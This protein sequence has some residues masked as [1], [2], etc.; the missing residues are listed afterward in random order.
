MI[1][2]LSEMMLFLN[3]CFFSGSAEAQ[4]IGAVGNY[5]TYWLLTFSVTRLPN[6][7]KIRQCFFE[8]QLKMSGMFFETQC[9]T[10]V[11]GDWSLHCGNM[12]LGPFLLLRP[13]PWPDDLHIRTLPVFHGD[14]PDLQ[15]RTSYV[16]AFVSYRL[17]DRQ[18]RHTN[19][20]DQNYKARRFAFA[21]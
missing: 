2:H 21:Q 19:R 6:L 10:K 17:T 4:A 15:T 9:R 13:W 5:S 3:Y 12:H 16:K 20:I 14:T 11:M 1:R 8:L 7:M 18:T